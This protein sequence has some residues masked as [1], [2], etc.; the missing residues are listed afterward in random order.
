MNY[1]HSGASRRRVRRRL[2]GMAP[3]CLAALSG[4]LPHGVEAQAAPPDTV[5]VIPHTHW[6]G[7]VFKTREEYL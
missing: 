1:F 6:E 7:A 4:L 2:A 5:Y 3:W